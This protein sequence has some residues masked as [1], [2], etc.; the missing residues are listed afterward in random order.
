MARNYKKN[1]R[2]HWSYFQNQ[3]WKQENWCIKEPHFSRCDHVVCVSAHEYSCNCIYVGGSGRLEYHVGQVVDMHCRWN[4]SYP[5]LGK[6]WVAQR[7]QVFFVWFLTERYLLV[8]VLTAAASSF[9]PALQGMNRVVK[10][11]RKQQNVEEDCWKKSAP[12]RSPL[13]FLLISHG[14]IQLL[15]ENQYCETESPCPFFLV[16]RHVIGTQMLHFV[17]FTLII[18]YAAFGENITPFLIISLIMVWVSIMSQSLLQ[19]PLPSPQNIQKIIA[20]CD[21]PCGDLVEV[22]TPPR[23]VMALS[24][25]AQAL[26]VTMVGLNMGFRL[27]CRYHIWEGRVGKELQVQTTVK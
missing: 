26:V 15:F 18:H 6:L 7:R 3:C 27:V 17:M 19:P 20:A 16:P 10:C 2:P 8:T 4:I 5:Q 12:R 23:S 21:C 24:Y 9:V 14:P 25:I 13:V 22:E 11:P 1:P